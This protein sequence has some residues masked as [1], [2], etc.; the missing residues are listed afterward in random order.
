[1]KHD[2][3][4][5]YFLSLEISFTLVGYI[6]TH[7]KYNF[8]MLLQANITYCKVIDPPIE[9]NAC[10][11]LSVHEPLCDPK[12]DKHFFGSLVDLIVTQPN[13][14]VVVHQMAQFMAAL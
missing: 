3:P 14:S 4:L 5:S 10:P 8:D 11:I 13:I 7:G 9:L 2:G 1:M 12:L 6:F